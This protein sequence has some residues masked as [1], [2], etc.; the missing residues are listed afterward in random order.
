MKLEIFFGAW[1]FIVEACWLIYGNTFIYDD[2]IKNCSADF[3]FFF[4]KTF[5]VSVKTL[6]NTALVLIIYGY[7]L[8]LGI[9]FTIFFYLGAYLGYKSYK[10]GDLEEVDRLKDSGEASG[11]LS[12]NMGTHSH[13]P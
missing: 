2:A 10:K 1:L 9:L 7:I 13:A 11:L 12:T 5:D 3:F 6:R 4:H 8:F